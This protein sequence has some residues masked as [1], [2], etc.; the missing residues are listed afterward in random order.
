MMLR[1]KTIIDVL[2]FLLI[3]FIPYTTFRVMGLKIS[4]IIMIIL[5]P[6][7]ISDI[8]IYKK[9]SVIRFFMYFSIAICTSALVNYLLGNNLNKI[10]LDNGIY[11]SYEYGFIFKIVRLF[12]VCIF[13]VAI[14]SIFKKYGLKKYINVY[15]LSTT[16]INIYGI[17]ITIYR[18]NIILGVTRNS[19]FAVEPSEAGFI[20]S[21]SIIIIIIISIVHKNFSFIQF[22]LLVIHIVMHL[23]IGSL[24]SLMFG[25][26]T[27]VIL[28]LVYF[29][30]KRGLRNF[31]KKLLVVFISC[32]S[33]LII[34]KNTSIFN[35]LINYKHY[36][37][38]QGGS[39][40]ERITAIDI[41]FEM[42]LDNMLLGVGW[43][44]YGWFVQLYNTN[45]LFNI[46]PGGFFSAN[47]QYIVILSELG[48]V[49]V[50][51][52][53]IF[54]LSCTKRIIYLFKLHIEEKNEL[55][56]LYIGTGMIIYVMLSNLTLNGI[57]SFQL[58]IGIAII[59]YLY[60]KSRI[61]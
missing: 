35:K 42:F 15:V 41:G 5:I 40:V 38:V 25:L 28:F 9:D 21:I 55:V 49:G 23:F 36:M 37:N 50:I 57:Y 4:E 19:L 13:S 29:G 11:Y 32:I 58:W 33:V 18:K 34:I 51:I 56:E 22:F 27:I 61:N 12:I 54:A 43:G 3:F 20:N 2:L 8:K 1:K 30:R 14:A 53:T 7:I 48:I 31:I 47:N 59:N 44:N 6:F 45:P 52:T 10:G 39:L 16:L 46:N 60:Y 26:V 24:A 17:I